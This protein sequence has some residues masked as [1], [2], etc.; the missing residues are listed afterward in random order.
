MP[1]RE[2]PDVQDIVHRM[3]TGK[4]LPKSWTS[5]RTKRVV[6]PAG[7]TVT[8]NVTPT[9]LDAVDRWREKRGLSRADALL[10]LANCGMRSFDHATRKR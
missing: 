9:M 2:T 3:A 7:A 10:F 1:R 4:K 5:P 6:E 8:V